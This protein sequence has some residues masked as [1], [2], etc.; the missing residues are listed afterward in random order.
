MVVGDAGEIRSGLVAVFHIH[1]SLGELPFLFVGNFQSPKNGHLEKKIE[2][3][4]GEWGNR[5]GRMDVFWGTAPSKLPTFK[6]KHD[7]WTL[8]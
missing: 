8:P 6:K 5:Q 7:E 3:K 2:P 1:E 4:M